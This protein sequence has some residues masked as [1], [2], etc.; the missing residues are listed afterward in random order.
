[1]KNETIISNLIKHLDVSHTSEI[2]LK[3][4]NYGNNDDGFDSEYLTE[5]RTLL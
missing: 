3:L 1:M 5:R 4:I 2:L